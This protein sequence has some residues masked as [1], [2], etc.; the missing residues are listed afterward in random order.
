MS[1]D[2]LVFCNCLEKGN[3][4]RPPQ[5]QWRVFVQQ[6]GC[7]ECASPDPEHQAAFG[8]WH[9]T[10]CAHDYGI[11]Q[12]CVLP[13]LSELAALESPPAH[14][15]VLRQHLLTP[16]EPLASYLDLPV[17]TALSGELPGL[18]PLAAHFPAVG[19]LLEGLECLVDAS[20]RVRKPIV[21]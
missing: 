19:R 6:D 7:R 16:G 21:I 9:E 20:L 10:A 1:I 18:R 5:P 14:F 2:A 15:P 3:L 11:L 8:R 17:V 13:P 12:H 4:N